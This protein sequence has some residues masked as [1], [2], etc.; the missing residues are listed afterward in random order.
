MSIDY[1]EFIPKNPIFYDTEILYIIE[2]IPGTWVG[3]NIT[4]DKLTSGFWSS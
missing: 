3:K 4:Y 1:K 2:A